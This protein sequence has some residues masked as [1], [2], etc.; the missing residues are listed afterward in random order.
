[1]SVRAIDHGIM[2]QKLTARVTIAIDIVDDGSPVK[3][4]DELAELALPN[5]ITIKIFSQTNAGQSAARNAAGQSEASADI[6]MAGIEMVHM[7]RKQQGLVA[8][9]RVRPFAID[10]LVVVVPRDHALTVKKRVAFADILHGPFVG[11]T[12]ALQ[13]N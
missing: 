12:G 5:H 10:R 7:M 9:S 3:A 1:M 6:T 8:Y 13:R 2:E 11:L 4:A